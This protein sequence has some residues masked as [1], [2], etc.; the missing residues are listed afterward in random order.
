MASKKLHKTVLL[1]PKLKVPRKYEPQ[2]VIVN[3]K[4]NSK[5]NKNRYLALYL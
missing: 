3:D 1:N 4:C 5:F 2:T